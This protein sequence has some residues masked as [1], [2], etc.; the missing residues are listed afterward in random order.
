[1][2][3]GGLHDEAP[4]GG[5]GEAAGLGDRHHVPQLLEFHGSIVN[6][7]GSRDKHVLDSFILVTNT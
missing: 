7:D 4:P 2:A 6:H 1:V 5:L 3:E